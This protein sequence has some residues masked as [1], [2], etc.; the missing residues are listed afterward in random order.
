MRHEKQ[1][2]LMYS[3][4][5]TLDNATGLHV[6]PA[7]L[8][9]EAASRFRS[10]IRVLKNTQAADGKSAISLMLLEALRGTEL[11]IEASG[12]DEIAAVEALV[13]LVESR[14]EIRS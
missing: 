6:R 12:E 9:M 7:T 10:A 2:G 4:R 5:V 3:K 8:F 11:T 14:F 13:E 1:S